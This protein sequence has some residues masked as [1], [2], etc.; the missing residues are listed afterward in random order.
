VKR[1][2]REEREES[3]KNKGEGK[4]EESIRRNVN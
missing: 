2:N 4:T 3:K 1:V